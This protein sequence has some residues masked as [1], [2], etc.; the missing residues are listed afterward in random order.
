MFNLSRCRHIFTIAYFIYFSGNDAI[1]KKYFALQSKYKEINKKKRKRLHN[2][3]HSKFN[4]GDDS[5]F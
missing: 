2:K 4:L 3:I 1:R 5:S